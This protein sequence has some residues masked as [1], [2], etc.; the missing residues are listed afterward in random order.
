MLPH[1]IY[2]IIIALCVT[3]IA[4]LGIYYFVPLK[5]PEDARNL[6]I[7]E[8]N[9]M[10]KIVSNE[11]MQ[12]LCSNGKNGYYFIR[13][14]EIPKIIKISDNKI[15]S[16]L[17]CEKIQSD[18]DRMWINS[19]YITDG[20]IYFTVSLFYG[21]EETNVIYKADTTLLSC[22]LVVENY[23]LGDITSYRF[24]VDGG[25]IY[26]TLQSGEKYKIASRCGYE[27]KIIYE[28]DNAIESLMIEDNCLFIRDCN[29]E[30]LYRIDLETKKI[31][32]MPFGT[33][34]ISDIKFSNIVDI[35]FVDENKRIMVVYL[36]SHDSSYDLE[37]E[38]V[39]YFFDV[40]TG[41]KCKLKK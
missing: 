24:V 10:D 31:K 34:Q 7:K 35:D 30:K 11:A 22:E 3:I 19:A 23:K 5:V 2:V 29:K 28:S 15:L 20:E 38:D 13:D 1:K 4:S 25:V 37:G 12:Y 6:A 39:V 21:F 26:Y 40:K 17:D 8:I 32:K 9:F 16:E 14:K 41:R 33:V 36:K 27:E 18:A